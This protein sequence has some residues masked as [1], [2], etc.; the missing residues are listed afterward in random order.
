[1]VS[2]REVHTSR[3]STKSSVENYSSRCGGI[4]HI[5][6]ISSLMQ[7][8]ISDLIYAV[9]LLVGSRRPALV[10]QHCKHGMTIRTSKT[11]M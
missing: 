5:A 11:S 6:G 10:G 7:V 2:V 8:V 3:H 1:M 9:Y 4:R